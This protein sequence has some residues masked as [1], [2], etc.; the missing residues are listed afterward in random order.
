[1]KM[2]ISTLVVTMLAI[3]IFGFSSNVCLAQPLYLIDISQARVSSSAYDI[4]SV[5][6]CF[7]D[8]VNTLMRSANV[9]PAYITLEFPASIPLNKAGVLL[10]QLGQHDIDQNLWWLEAANSFSEL[11]SKTGSYVVAVDSGF[12]AGGDWNYVLFD[13]TINRKIWRINFKK[14][15]GDNYVHVWEIEFL[16]Y[17]IIDF[18]TSKYNM[19]YE[20][21]A[22][23][24]VINNSANSPAERVFD[25]DQN[26]GLLYENQANP[27]FFFTLNRDIRLKK[28][29]VL[30]KGEVEWELEYA[31]TYKDLQSKTG[32][33][34]ITPRRANSTMVWDTVEFSEITNR[35]HFRIVI[36]NNTGLSNLYL[37]EIEFYSDRNTEKLVGLQQ[38]LELWEGWNWKNNPK[39]LIFNNILKIKRE[40]CTWSSTAPINLE[41]DGIIKANRWGKGQIKAKFKNAECVMNITVKAPGKPLEKETLNEFIGKPAENC[42]YEVPVIIV[43]YIPST[44]GVNK[45]TKY[46]PEYLDLNWR[47]ISEVKAD[48]IESIQRFKF[49]I[50]EGS[51][52]RKYKN[53]DAVPN[54]GL[55]VVEYIT[56][57]EPFPPG[58]VNGNY[59]NGIHKYAIDFERVFKQIGL[60]AKIQQNKVKY[61]WVL[62]CGTN[63]FMPH[64]DPDS[65]KPEYFRA[66]FE[67]FM[68]TPTGL[69]AC[70]GVNPEPLPGYLGTYTVINSY[71]GM[72]E[73]NTNN[74][75]C[76]THQ[77]EALLVTQ[78]RLRDDN[79]SL[80]WHKFVGKKGRCGWTHTP[81]NTE[82]NYGY[83][84]YIQ[85]D[86]K[87]VQPYLCDIE[88]WKPDNSGEKKMISHHTWEDIQ[89]NWPDGATDFEGRYELQW[90]IYWLQSIPGYNNNIPYKH[91]DTNWVI[92]NWWKFFADW[93]KYALS[94]PGLYEL[95][96]LNKIEILESPVALCSGNKFTLKYL[97]NSQYELSNRFSVQL[98]NAS[99]NFNNPLMLGFVNSQSSGTIN[100]TIPHNLPSSSEYKIRVVSSHPQSALDNEKIIFIHR[101]PNPSISINT[102]ACKNNIQTIHRN[103]EEDMVYKW[104]VEGGEII[105]C[106]TCVEVDILWNSASKGKVI[107]NATNT[108]MCVYEDTA[109]VDINPLP[110]VQITGEKTVCQNENYEF[111]T[112]W[113]SKNEY[114]WSVANGDLLTE[115]DSYR[116]TVKFPEIGESKIYLSLKS[117]NTQCKDSTEITVNVVEKPSQPTVTLQDGKLVSSSPVG[118]QWY[119]NGELLQ[120]SV[121]QWIYPSA[122]GAYTVKYKSGICFSD[123]S[124]AY[125]Y[126]GTSVDDNNNLTTITFHLISD[127][128]LLIVNTQEV[129]DRIEIYSAIGNMVFA[130]NNLIGRNQ[131]DVSHL[132][133]GMYFAK[134]GNKLVKLIK[135]R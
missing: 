6:N 88:D 119:L 48:Y 36:Y 5:T 37:N 117:N 25:G 133:Q 94:E 7:D 69:Q 59:D 102:T 30:F 123:L 66:S 29:A 12:R 87:Q 60:N 38:N 8:N 52:F 16:T 120:D 107:L 106:D 61:V 51:R 101:F 64:Y 108:A 35:K 54:I 27:Y 56:I 93:D 75:E 1:M 9:N 104:R 97:T 43:Q 55:K 125:N 50:E 10:G 68:E 14:V 90:F 121:N 130:A 135:A 134:T 84:H 4:G 126:Q 112:A 40:D 129:V 110:V 96:K 18:A 32:T 34:G 58:L 65:V 113:D 116:I 28:L 41:D 103:A 128:N 118:N 81:P 131:F 49:A 105:G 122:D 31:E 24:I 45:D 114:K 98:S 19:A 95:P 111:S 42:I 70:N 91:N 46:S 3:G 62:G 109:F 72:P 78:N 2:R 23:N 39:T 76:F 73:F 26:S 20:L 47:P 67:S 33:Y 71:M 82:I 77:F 115:D 17:S 11:N 79:D 127:D 132:P 85:T 92:S 83:F 80:F 89:Y 74:M 86:P 99:G 22:N 21:K 13:S 57:Y 63:A 15:V 44:D 53:P 124:S 100:C